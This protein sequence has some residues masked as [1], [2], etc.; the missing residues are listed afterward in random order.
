MNN[1]F[2]IWQKIWQRLYFLCC[3]AWRLNNDALRCSLLPALR[4]GGA[5]LGKLLSKHNIIKWTGEDWFTYQ[6]WTFFFAG[7]APFLDLISFVA[8]DHPYVKKNFSHN[9][10]YAA[11]GPYEYQGVTI[12]PG[13]YIVDAGANF[14]LFA[15]LATEKIGPT[16]R[17]LAFEPVA[18]TAKALAKTIANNSIINIELVTKALGSANG[19]IKFSLY[20]S[21]LSSSGYGHDD[22]T[23]KGQELVEQITLDNFLIAKDWPR[24]DFIKADIE[25]MERDMLI[26]AKQSIRRFKPKLAICIYHR[27]DDPAVIEQLIRDMVP[28]YQ[29]ITTKTKLYAW[30]E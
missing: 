14:G 16:G 27:P 1:H 28:E 18:Q 20:D 21:L 8:I 4:R 10:M 15:I 2:A 13:D 19:Q 3:Q 5:D 23:T 22:Q 9:I 26:G 12:G 29:I 24:L 25:G 6:N 7:Q 11:E 30:V 17:L